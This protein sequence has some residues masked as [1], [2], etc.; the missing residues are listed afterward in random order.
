MRVTT[1]G[2]VTIPQRLREKFGITPES[3]VDFIEEK[4]RIYIV[5]KDGGKPPTRK[6]RRLRGIATVKMTT[7]E[8]MALTRG[9]E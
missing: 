1:K 9:K 8:I 2:Q 5:K 7:D 3:E 4:G 6:F